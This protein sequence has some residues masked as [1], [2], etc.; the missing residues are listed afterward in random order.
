M[1]NWYFEGSATGQQWTILDARIYNSDSQ[2]HNNALQAEFKELQR[3]GG[4]MT[5]QID[6]EIYRK[7]GIDGYRFFRIVQVGKN[8]NSTDNLALSGFELYGRISGSPW[9]FA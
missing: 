1:R 7:L 5:F 4:A 2:E 9:T 6:T 8:T 3:R